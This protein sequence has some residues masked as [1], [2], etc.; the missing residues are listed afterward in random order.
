M[1]MFKFTVVTAD[2]MFE[3]RTAFHSFANANAHAE[4]LIGH[5]GAQS[6][7]VELS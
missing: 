6:V 5:Y 4:F 7:T 1:K 2:C 3:W